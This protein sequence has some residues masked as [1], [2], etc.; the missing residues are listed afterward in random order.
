VLDWRADR[1]GEAGLTLIE[2][3]V[4]MFI[5]ATAVVALIAALG[6][7]IV[8]SDMHRKTV[9]ADAVVRSWAEKLQAAPYVSCAARTESSYQPA[10]LAVTV[11][12]KFTPNLKSVEYWDGNPTAGF[13]PTCPTTDNGVERITLIVS[14]TDGRGAQSV[15]ILKRKP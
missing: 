3:V 5:L 14:S 12:T 15:Q 13:G 1:D 7:S 9:T 6:T 11:P 10:A 8:A 2:C 4:A